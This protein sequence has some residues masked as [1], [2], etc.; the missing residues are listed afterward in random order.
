MVMARLH[1]RL[2]E[3]EGATLLPGRLEDRLAQV[4]PEEVDSVI[5]DPPR[6]G[7][8]PPVLDEL[9][10]LG[11]ERIVYVSCDPA[12]LARDLASL[13]D[14]G[15]RVRAQTLVDMFPQTYHVETVS[16]LHR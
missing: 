6:A 16:L 2:H 11:P 12:T 5:I 7:V 9:A 14:D 8:T 1:L 13:S 4:E 10:R 15:Y 3:V